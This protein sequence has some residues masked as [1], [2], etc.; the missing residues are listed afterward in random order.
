MDIDKAP[1]SLSFG[2][3]V[4]GDASGSPHFFLV[5]AEPFQYSVSSPGHS[6][7]VLSGGII[8]WLPSTVMVVPLIAILTV[9]TVINVLNLITI[10]FVLTAD[11]YMPVILVNVSSETKYLYCARLDGKAVL[12]TGTGGEAKKN[13][14]F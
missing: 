3:D 11:S 13:P 2:I 4:T 1:A 9:G 8:D 12:K 14:G 5:Q 6:P 7:S 10:L